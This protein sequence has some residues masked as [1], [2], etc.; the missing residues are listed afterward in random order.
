MPATTLQ[1]LI[2]QSGVVQPAGYKV[3]D[4]GIAVDAAAPN[5]SETV[6]SRLLAVAL[7]P[8]Q[9]KHETRK[10]CL[11]YGEQHHERH[12]P[13]ALLTSAI[14]RLSAFR[15]GLIPSALLAQLPSLRSTRILILC[16]HLKISASPPAAWDITHKITG[17]EIFTGCSATD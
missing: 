4:T 11:S 14:I 12:A 3:D 5:T 7:F 16:G 10:D 9:R 15:P 13:S 6:L 17:G 2:P 8:T 1:T